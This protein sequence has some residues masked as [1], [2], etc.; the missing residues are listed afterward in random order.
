MKKTFLLMAC[1]V[2]L[3]LPLNPIPARAEPLECAGLVQI[4]LDGDGALHE[5]STQFSASK[6]LQRGSRVCILATR[7]P[8]LATWIHVETNTGEKGWISE[9]RLGS[10]EEYRLPIATAEPSPKV[11]PPLIPAKGD[12][13]RHFR[14]EATLRECTVVLD[15]QG[16]VFSVR[17][18]PGPGYAPTGKFVFPNEQVCVLHETGIWHFIRKRDGTTGYVYSVGTSLHQHVSPLETPAELLPVDEPGVQ[19]G[20]HILETSLDREIYLSSLDALTLA[21]QTNLFDYD[22]QDWRHW[23]DTD[24]DCQNTRHEVLIEESQTAVSFTRSDGCLVESGQWTGPWGGLSFTL[25]SD[26]DV[27]H[28]VPLKNAHI[29]GGAAWPPDKKREYANDMA[30][31]SALQAMQDDLNQAKGASGPEDWK[32]PLQ[33]SWCQYAKDWVDV[34]SKWGLSVTIDEKSALA[35]ML[36]TCADHET[37][38]QEVSSDG[39]NPPIAPEIPLATSSPDPASVGVAKQNQSVAL[40]ECRVHD[41]FVRFRNSSQEAVNLTGYTIHD[42]G[43]NFTYSFAKDFTI[44]PG[45]T[46]TLYSN[47]DRGSISAQ[48]NE[49]HFTSRNVWNNTGDAAYLLKG[50]S[51]LDQVDCN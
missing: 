24:R 2:I 19:L 5:N 18:G 49:L 31:D 44:G 17:T 16:R 50:T 21:D 37:V 40:I 43:A 39:K 26:L 20:D 45:E 4:V 30:L 15:T 28:H 36:N 13:A 9:A 25:A 46:W 14:S 12:T 3:S 22:R 8:I 41:E 42:E 11:A 27:D 34:K 35:E 23:I 7:K 48:Q 47:R 10:E 29:S 6:D 51:L 32:P 1:L 38:Q 33:S